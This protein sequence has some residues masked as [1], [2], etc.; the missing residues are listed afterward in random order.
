MNQ[1]CAKSDAGRDEIKNRSRKLSR[2]AR[3]LLLVMD[4]THTAQDWLHLVHGATEADL[5]QL[6]SEGLIESKDEPQAA[7]PA[8]AAS[9]AEAI[10]RLSYDQLYSL[11]TSQA[12]ERFGLIKGYKM[13]L[14]VE[15]CSNIEELRALAVKFLDMVKQEQG[16]A[17][18]RQ[19]RVALGVPG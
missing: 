16:D 12:K 13:V 3:N 6:L 14:D 17:V 8:S 2:P 5:Q 9:M 18:Y 15:K 19:M 4:T 11:L 7:R 10:G 1:R